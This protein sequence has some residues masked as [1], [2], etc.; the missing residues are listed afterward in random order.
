M[1]LM[2]G[3]GIIDL[4]GFLQAL[5]KIGYNGGVS[6]EPLGRIPADMSTEDAAKLGYDTTLAVMKKAGVI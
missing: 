1:R 2:P 6:P 5:Q 3:E 4:V